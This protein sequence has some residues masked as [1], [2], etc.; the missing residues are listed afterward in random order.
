MGMKAAYICVSDCQGASDGQQAASS[1]SERDDGGVG[2]AG[3]RN[4]CRA[5]QARHR[6]K[7]V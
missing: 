4:S 6:Q 1:Q 7:G 5:P 3:R 2:A